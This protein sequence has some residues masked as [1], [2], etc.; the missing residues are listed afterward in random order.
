MAIFS[1]KPRTV[2]LHA[3]KNRFYREIIVNKLTKF[4]KF[5]LV[6]ILFLALTFAISPSVSLAACNQIY[7][8]LSTKAVEKR[9]GPIAQVTIG[10]DLPAAPGELGPDA[11]QKR[12][13]T[14]CALCHA[15][16]LA[17]APKFGDKTAWAPHVAKGFDTLLQSAIHGLNAM[18]PRGGCTTCSDEELKLTV[19]YMLSKVK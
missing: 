5:E 10:A 9:L 11:G 3:L 15:G 7:S 8:D 13:E 17:G 16:G 6:A 18:P 14:S 4:F 2:I 19:Q 12:Y 1:I